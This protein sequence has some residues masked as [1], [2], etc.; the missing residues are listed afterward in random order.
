MGK[1]TVDVRADNIRVKVK[2]PPSQCFPH[3]AQT[4][5]SQLRRKDRLPRLDL[6]VDEV[7]QVEKVAVEPNK[8]GAVVVLVDCVLRLGRSVDV[9]VER[10]WRKLEE[11][12]GG[13]ARRV[14]SLRKRSQKS[15]FGLIEEATHAPE[16]QQSSG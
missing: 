2:R 11:I 1:R 9:I 7:N 10:R 12:G 13:G 3:P 16:L 8:L 15:G 6:D 14:D 4:F 5:C